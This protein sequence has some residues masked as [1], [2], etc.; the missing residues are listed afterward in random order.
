MNKSRAHCF[1]AALFWVGVLLLPKMSLAAEPAGLATRRVLSRVQAEQNALKNQ[2]QIARA[3]AQ[4]RVALAHADQSEASFYPGVVASA[5]YARRTANSGSQLGGLP[6]NTGGKSSFDTFNSYNFGITATQLVYDFGQTTGGYRAAQANAEAQAESEAT[7]RLNVLLAVRTA[8]ALAWANRAQVEVARHTLE[9]ADHHLIQVQ[10]LAD[11]GARP[12]IDLAQVRADRASAELQLINVENAYETAKAQLNQAM[13]SDVG[14]D[15]DVGDEPL[16]EVMGEALYE[17]QLIKLAA[18]GR[19]ELRSLKR[20]VDANELQ[21]SASKA[22]I[23]P[24]LGVSTSLTES[25]PEINALAWNWSAGANLTWPLFQG[26]ITNAR[27]REAVANRE[28]SRSELAL[29]RQQIR[30]EVTQAHFAL[31]GAKASLNAAHEV[32]K[33][34]NERLRLAEARYQA[35]AGSIIELEDAETQASSASGQVVQAEYS[36]FVGRAQLERALGRW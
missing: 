30:L 8:F 35:G 29:E 25:G 6:A 10:G 5:A 22:G 21:I 24:S 7:T 36:I 34:A 13:G 19:P 4:T 31:R 23:A 17:E 16:A 15:Y 32:Q 2:P 20:Q 28:V 3:K 12:Q 18:S 1:F 11:A 33:N 14:T 26:G 27:V 9:N